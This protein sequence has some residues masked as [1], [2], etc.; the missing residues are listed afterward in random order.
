ML[1]GKPQVKAMNPEL[2]AALGG[3]AS[4]TD[5]LTEVADRRALSTTINSGGGVDATPSLKSQAAACAHWAK[6]NSGFWVLAVYNEQFVNRY[7]VPGV[8]FL[9]FFKAASL[10]PAHID[11]AHKAAEKYVRAIAAHPDDTEKPIIVPANQPFLI[12]FSEQTA[13]DAAH[14]PAK[15]ARSLGRHTDVVAFRKED[16]RQAK[17]QTGTGTAI[18]E[19]EFHVMRNHYLAAKRTFEFDDALDEPACVVLRR[20]MA[21]C[22]QSYE[23]LKVKYGPAVAAAAAAAASTAADD[24][25]LAAP[26]T[27]AAPCLDDDDGRAPDSTPLVAAPAAA[28]APA[29]PPKTVAPTAVLDTV[30]AKWTK[31][32]TTFGKFPDTLRSAS[33]K[34]ALT[35]FLSDWDLPA[36]STAYPDAAGME[37]IC[38]PFGGEYETEEDARAAV[39]D[40]L[41]MFV[42][43]V[44]V[45]CVKMYKTLF[46]SEVNEDSL[47]TTHRT[48]NASA[49]VEL[50]KVMQSRIGQLDNVH[51][52]EQ[53]NAMSDRVIIPKVIAGEDVVPDIDDDTAAAAAAEPATIVS[54]TQ[55]TRAEARMRSDVSADPIEAAF[56]KI[57]AERRAQNGGSDGGPAVAP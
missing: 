2:D 57:A 37:W 8:Q 28:A 25:P 48:D 49:Q 15:L 23:R 51:R 54:V 1:S 41:N 26:D 19:T 39:V 56:A 36:D 14:V 38:V 31:R 13:T 12:P 47:K 24:T 53:F 6:H 42:R 32:D 5:T 43:D 22:R 46:P 40:Q 52:A 10:S 20:A 45:S 3:R 35:S 33:G 34:F 44:P 7:M 16:F 18:E 11:A 55:L 27:Y 4:L 17:N 30:P 50:N 21:L 9:R 29:A